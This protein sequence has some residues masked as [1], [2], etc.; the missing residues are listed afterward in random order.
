MRLAAVGLLLLWGAGCIRN[1]GVFVAVDDY[2][3]PP[4]PNAD[5]VIRVGDTVSV[6]V[7]QQEAMS[8]RARV[9]NDGKISLP[10][11]NDVSV[12]GFAPNAV[13]SQLQVRLKDFINNPIVTV[14]LDEIRQLTI[15]VLGEVLRPGQLTFEPGAGLLQAL[16]ASG[17]FTLFARRDIFV[18]RSLPGESAPVRVRFTFDALSHGEGKGPLFRLRNGDVVIVE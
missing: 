6:R 1:P 14:S 2:V 17:G 8:A 3:A 4:E 15:S 13:A 9:R 11:L 18:M 5:S 12:A 10:F 16:A 7:F